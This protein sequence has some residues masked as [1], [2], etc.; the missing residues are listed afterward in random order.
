MLG[1]AENYADRDERRIISKS[2]WRA[3][4]EKAQGIAKT[5]WEG[6]RIVF[7][8]AHLHMN[9]AF[10]KG[11]NIS[12]RY[13]FKTYA[14]NIMIQYVNLQGNHCSSVYYKNNLPYDNNHYT[15]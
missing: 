10:Q 11:A 2:A 14:K 9:T 1:A 8:S 4:L 7:R 5:L 15:H 6:Q 13:Q 12:T 3:H